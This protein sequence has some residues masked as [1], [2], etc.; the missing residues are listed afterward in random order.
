MSIEKLKSNGAAALSLE[1]DSECSVLVLSIEVC[2]DTDILDVRLAARVEI[3]VACNACIA[4]VVLIFEICAIAPAEY[5]HCN[6]ILARLDERGDVKFFLKLIVFAV[7]NILAIDPYVHVARS[8][9]DMDHYLTAIPACRNLDLTAIVSD[10][11]I[12]DRH[13]WGVVLVLAVP[14]VRDVSVLRITIA[15]EFPHARD[16]H[17]SPCLIVV[18]CLVEVAYIIDGIFLP[19]EFPRAIDVEIVVRQ[20]LVL[21]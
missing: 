5:L 18:G 21:L 9:T 8:S 17:C 7:A 3:A 6:E 19:R 14:S 15:I 1:I 12:L 4:E 10:V 11:V 16:W 20:L 13:V 2:I